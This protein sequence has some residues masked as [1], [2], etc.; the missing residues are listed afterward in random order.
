M[1]RKIK[2]TCQY[3]HTDNE[4]P[5]S[6]L[7]GNVPLVDDRGSRI[8]PPTVDLD[9][10]SLAQMLVQCSNCNGPIHCVSATIS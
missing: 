1:A 5:T 6:D 7:V 9:E 4:F 8:D 10:E 2:V 3:C